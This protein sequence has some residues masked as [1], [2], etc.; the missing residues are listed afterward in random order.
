M[1]P[2]IVP[3]EFRAWKPFCA[4]IVCAPP[5]VT[6]TPV[7]VR[8]A[9]LK[10]VAFFWK[11]EIEPPSMKNVSIESLSTCTP[12]PRWLPLTTSKPS[13]VVPPA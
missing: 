8:S 3:G 2:E 9:R 11:S 5:P 13:T 6:V 4:L 12:I 10:T 1:L 7:T